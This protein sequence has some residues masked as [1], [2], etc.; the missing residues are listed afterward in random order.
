MKALRQFDDVR[1]QKV[2][3]KTF[4]SLH[5]LSNCTFYFPSFSTFPTELEK[6][7]KDAVLIKRAR[8]VIEEIERTKSA[9]NALRNKDFANVSKI[10]A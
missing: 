1:V 8:H 10:F 5:P 4:P 7:C 6:I 9:A 3:I 2:V